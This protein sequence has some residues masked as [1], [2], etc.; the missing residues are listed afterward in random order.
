MTFLLISHEKIKKR[1]LSGN[2]LFLNCHHISIL[3]YFICQ[4]HFYW[5]FL[6]LINF[7]CLFNKVFVNFNFNIFCFFISL[8]N[9]R[10]LWKLKLWTKKL[11]KFCYKRV[12][13]MMLEIVTI[14]NH[15][16]GVVRKLRHAK[17][18]LF[19]KIYFVLTVT[20]CLTPQPPP[21][22]K[23]VTVFANHS[24]AN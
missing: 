23:S 11:I 15:Q 5:V 6:I 18:W 2:I 10:W 22:K 9:C 4:N 19:R 12:L 3:V 21:P 1:K 17:N 16:T 7:L 8:I 14:T 20:K 24:K 13:F